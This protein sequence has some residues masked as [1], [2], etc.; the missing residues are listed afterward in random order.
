[1]KFTFFLLFLLL[2][3]LLHVD[4]LRWGRVARI[5]WMAA[6]S[7]SSSSSGSPSVTAP[8]LAVQGSLRYRWRPIASAVAAMAVPA[9][10]SVGRS[11]AIT[12]PR[13]RSLPGSAASPIISPGP[14]VPVT[15]LSFSR[16]FL[17]CPVWESRFV[18]LAV[19]GHLAREVLLVQTSDDDIH[20][21]HS[22]YF[23]FRLD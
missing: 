12:A 19:R 11:L 9:I 22:W 15:H 14:L 6:R 3:T 18:L 1:M 10:P 7:G 2:F 4:A 23:G 8:V 17:A 20:R 13:P 21:S 16:H 5:A